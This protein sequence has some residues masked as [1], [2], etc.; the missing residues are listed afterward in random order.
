MAEKRNSYRSILKGTSIFGGVQVFQVLLSL[1]RGK[2]VALFLGPAGMGV[3][4]LFQSVLTTVT[5]MSSLGLNL[6]IVKEVAHRNS[7]SDPSADSDS[8][9][10]KS[11]ADPSA[12]SDSGLEKS[13]S[14]PVAS[15]DAVRGIY[16]VVRRLILITAGA[17]A[18][19]TLCFAPWLSRVSFG[20]EEYTLPF[21]LLAAAVAF[22]VIS[23]GML[24]ILQGMHAVRLMARASLFGGVV[25]LVVSVPLYW[26]F[27]TRGIVPAIVI[28]ALSMCM[29][30]WISARRLVPAPSPDFSFAWRDHIPLVRQL[31]VLGLLLMSGDLILAAVTYATNV[32]IRHVGD[33]SD[34]GLYQAANSITNQYAN[35]VFM[36]MTLDYFPR[37]TAA[38]DDNREMAGIVNRQFEIVALIASPLLSLLVMFTPLAVH[39]LLTSKFLTIIPLIRWIALA[40]TVK[41]LMFPLGVITFAKDNKRIYFWMEAV[42][43]NILTLA[44]NCGLYLY[45]GLIG[46]GYALLIDCSVCL[47]VY[48]LVNRRLYDY[49]LSPEALRRGIL[50]LIF[51]VGVFA[52]SFI[53]HI[54]ISYLA[55]G[56]IMAISATYSFRSLRVL[57]KKD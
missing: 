40:V 48:L 4:A 43:A 53:P 38:A 54:F 39:I 7:L 14:T 45:C 55:M 3:N 32:F 6:A 13:P 50:A 25:G 57:L 24:S 26:L 30:Y 20:S 5:Q 1:I 46:L 49:R 12:D 44:L 36:A 31:L 56:V 22:T 2:F 34:V 41:A 11:S 37:L 10:G 15:P 23:N 35:V 51:A 52:A 18:I 47:V 8:G 17:G 19:F 16:E 27:G 29:V 33:L 28:L 42:G 9:S 21:M